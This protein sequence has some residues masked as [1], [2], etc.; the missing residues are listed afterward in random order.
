MP[1]SVWITSTDSVSRP[2][3]CGFFIIERQFT[4][5]D[6]CGRTLQRSQ[7]IRI[8]EPQIPIGEK[9]LNMI[10]AG[11]ELLLGRDNRTDCVVGSMAC[12]LNVQM[13]NQCGLTAED[14]F[15]RY[16]DWL[17]AGVISILNRG[18]L[19]RTCACTGRD[20][21]GGGR[22]EL[23]GVPYTIQADQRD[24][25][26]VQSAPMETPSPITVILDCPT[27]VTGCVGKQLVGTDPTYNI[28]TIP[29]E[30]FAFYTIVIDVP[31]TSFVLI[32]IISTSGATLMVDNPRVQGVILNNGL[33]ASHVLWNAAGPARLNLMVRRRGGGGGGGQPEPWAFR[34]TLLN[35]RGTIFID[36]NPQS[37]WQGQI[38]ARRVALN[39][40]DQTCGGHFVGFRPAGFC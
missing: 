28:F 2:D 20:C 26:T 30:D 21:A 10:Y 27:G 23:Y 12:G 29:E 11:Q 17:G 35:R 3:G 16:S 34:G 7:F 9:G 6:A 14:D 39:G 37:V 4:A 40:V 24:C 18:P 32:N 13:S 8:G 1:S 25:N 33:P 31:A 5:Q 15:E 22:D 19:M 38:L 36:T